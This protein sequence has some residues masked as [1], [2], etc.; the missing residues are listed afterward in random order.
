LAGKEILNRAYRRAA[1]TLQTDAEKPL[2]VDL[3]GVD[4]FTRRIAQLAERN[5]EAPRG[6]G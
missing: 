5:V 3:S 4:E 2:V 6:K 1:Q